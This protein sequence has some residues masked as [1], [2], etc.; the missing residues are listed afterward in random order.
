MFLDYNT[1]FFSILFSIFIN[2]YYYT[3]IK[4]FFIHIFLTLHNVETDLLIKFVAKT[5]INHCQK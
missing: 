5:D 4:V 3:K 2:R 1:F